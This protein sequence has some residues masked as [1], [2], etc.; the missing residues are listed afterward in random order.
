M[1]QPARMRQRCSARSPSDRNAPAIARA[2]ALTE[3]GS[4]VSPSNI[5]LARAGLSD[6]DPM[7]RIG[8][9]DMLEGVP[10]AQLWPLV[11]P[12][13]S[14]PSR[15]VR[16]RAASLLAA[17]PTAK[18]ACRRPR[19]LRARRSRVHRRAAAQRRRPE[20]RATLGKF[21][22]A[23]RAVA[24]AEAEYKAALRLSP[25][26][27]PAAVNLADLYRQLG[28]DGEGERVLRAAIATSP[29]DAGAAPRAWPGA[30]A[31][32]AARRGAR[33]IAP[34][35]RARARSGPIRLCLR[36]GAAFERPRRR[37]DDGAEGELART[38]TIA[39]PCWR[40]SA[41]AV[42][43]ETSIPRSNTP[44]GWRGSNPGLTEA[45]PASSE[46]P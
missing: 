3:L 9:L 30:G 2:S 7:V 5:D 45:W 17:V 19:A 29:R 43:P 14:D 8:A 41:S 40:S 12:L 36:G 16:I 26:F 27:A 28:R 20:A 22:R 37:G 21:L 24:D 31:A 13:L 1:D 10:P 44:S 34:R 15:G 18:P 42:T 33:R 35:R 11:S 46:E 23:A 25:Q 38:R 39:T 32:Q 4:H 6:P